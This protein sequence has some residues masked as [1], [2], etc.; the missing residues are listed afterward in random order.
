M[1]RKALELGVV[2]AMRLEDHGAANFYRQQAMAITTSLIDF[3]DAESGNWRAS[4]TT[5]KRTG[6]DCAIPLT[7]IHQSA[8]VVNDTQ[9]LSLGSARVL[10]TLREYA[11]SFEN[12]YTIN[13]NSSWMD[14]ML[15]GRYA[16]DIYDG[17]GTS[18]G[19]PW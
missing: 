3:E 5:D 12:L 15:L 4:T 19:N 17:V 6:L 10:N 9:V 7:I 18:K 8:S 16:E 14:G 1:S 11:K 13:S 2:L